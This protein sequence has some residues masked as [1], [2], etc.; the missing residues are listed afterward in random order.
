[1]DQ[2]ALLD[3]LVPNS[4]TEGFMSFVNDY[5][6]IRLEGRNKRKREDEARRAE[7]KEMYK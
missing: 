5:E 1:M 4:H 7:K 3:D 2:Q 6:G